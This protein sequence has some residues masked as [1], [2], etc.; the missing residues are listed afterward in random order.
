MFGKKDKGMRLNNL[1]ESDG[2]QPGETWGQYGARLKAEKAARREREIE[3]NFPPETV[4]EPEE[5]SPGDVEALSEPSESGESGDSMVMRIMRALKAMGGERWS[6]RGEERF[7]KRIRER[8][9]CRAYHTCD[10]LPHGVTENDIFDPV[11]YMPRKDYLEWYLKR[12]NCPVCRGDT[13]G[14]KNA[15]STEYG[16]PKEFCSDHIEL[17]SE[18][19]RKLMGG[20]HPDELEDDRRSRADWAD[21]RAGWIEKGDRVVMGTGVNIQH[22]VVVGIDHKMKDGRT[23]VVRWDKPKSRALEVTYVDPVKLDIEG[24]GD[25]KG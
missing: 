20:E 16:K 19:V 7:G 4:P 3:Q 22:G 8:P 21:E 18:H 2:R 9:I 23:H 25:Y 24:H 6:R 1:F 11:T 14:C 15:V 5:A 10:V 17:G 12:E 13:P